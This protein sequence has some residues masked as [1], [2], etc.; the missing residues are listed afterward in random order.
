M[1]DEFVAQQKDELIS[2]NERISSLLTETKTTETQSREQTKTCLKQ[3]MET[4][5]KGLDT[6]V[7][8]RDAQHGSCFLYRN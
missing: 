7:M 8:Q 3:L 2:K 4:V 5:V 6:A 1:F